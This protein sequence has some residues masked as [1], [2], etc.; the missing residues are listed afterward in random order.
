MRPPRRPQVD[1]EDLILYGLLL[2]IGIIPVMITLVERSAFG[3]DATLGL[4]MVVVAIV[5]LVFHVLRA[6]WRP[7]E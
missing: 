3:F 4:M 6:R 2:V 1:P 7:A 5:G